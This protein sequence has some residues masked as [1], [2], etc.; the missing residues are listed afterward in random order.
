MHAEIPIA[1]RLPTIT[2]RTAE[3]APRVR[4]TFVTDIY[5]GKLYDVGLYELLR[6]LGCRTPA[7]HGGRERPSI[8]RTR[9]DCGGVLQ[10][11]RLHP[12]DHPNAI[13]Q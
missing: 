13:D 5:D 7:T 2:G 10:G 6:M 8:S 12:R 11:D 4:S 1:E 9:G 3:V